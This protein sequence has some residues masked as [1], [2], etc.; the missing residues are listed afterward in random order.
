MS[1]GTRAAASWT[2][3]T[4]RG[5]RTRPARF[6][7][8]PAGPVR[9]LTTSPA[10]PRGAVFRRGSHFSEYAVRVAARRRLAERQ[11]GLLERRALGVPG[12]HELE[13]GEDRPRGRRAVQ[14]DEVDAGG[15]AGEQL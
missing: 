8:S 3:P 2:A 5:E 6:R 11:R 14:R 10:R 9:R 13:R 7:R 1:W 15:A 12:A 4:P